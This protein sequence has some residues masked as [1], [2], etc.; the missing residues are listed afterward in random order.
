MN[1]EIKKAL[2]EISDL[3][4]FYFS[5]NGFPVFDVMVPTGSEHV[6]ASNIVLYTEDDD[7]SKELGRINIK[8]LN[9]FL[10]V[11][12]HKV[13]VETLQD[14]KRLVPLFDLKESNAYYSI[15]RNFDNFIKDSEDNMIRYPHFY[16]D[17]EIQFFQNN[18]AVRYNTPNAKTRYIE[19]IAL[20]ESSLITND[21]LLITVGG[22][23]LDKLLEKNPLLKQ[24]YSKNISVY[25]LNDKQLEA[26]EMFFNVADALFPDAVRDFNVLNHLTI[27][28]KDYNIKLEVSC[29]KEGICSVIMDNKE[30]S[31]YK[32][33]DNCLDAAKDIVESF[34]K[35]K[36]ENALEDIKN[37]SNIR[38]VRIQKI[39]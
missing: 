26:K 18:S 27:Q 21:T 1:T 6:G 4:S 20:G 22:K 35:S 14:F 8:E 2:Q 36:K 16:V 15:T 25:K 29:D 10:D 30:N 39:K 38:N 19:N 5:K 11:N 32:I 33:Y 3:S 13:I 12:K 37:K 28:I 9:D 34:Y 24:L 17:S 23:A 7:L 31:I